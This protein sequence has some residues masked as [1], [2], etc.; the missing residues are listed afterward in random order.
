M[1]SVSDLWV[2]DLGLCVRTYTAGERSDVTRHLT[3]SDITLEDWMRNI[4]FY[5]FI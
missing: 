2:R 3:K 4:V 5:N 1:V